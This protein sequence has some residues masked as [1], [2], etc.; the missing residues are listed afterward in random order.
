MTFD[1]DEGGLAA[2]FLLSLLLHGLVLFVQWHGRSVVTPLWLPPLTPRPLLPTLTVTLRQAP[3]VM[4]ARP[5]DIPGLIASVAAAPPP[6]QQILTPQTPLA[7][8]RQPATGVGVIVEHYRRPSELT[9]APYPLTVD[10]LEF[11]DTEVGLEGGR[12][13]VEIYINELGR[14]DDAEIIFGAP[15]PALREKA[16]RVFGQTEYKPGLWKGQP[17]KSRLLVELMLPA[18]A[19]LEQEPSAEQ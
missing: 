13:V 4:D 15:P 5:P 14:V 6:L 11:S 16:K 1:R 12:F 2:S 18:R 19:S 17:V 10:S 8:K 7:P 9:E 3:Q